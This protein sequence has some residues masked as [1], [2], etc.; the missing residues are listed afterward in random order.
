MK[1]KAST[2]GGLKALGFSDADLYAGDK[3]LGYLLYAASEN[4]ALA[5]NLMQAISF[6]QQETVMA[7]APRKVSAA[8]RTKKVKKD[9]SLSKKN[10][11]SLFIGELEDPESALA[12]FLGDHDVTEATV[13]AV[14]A[15]YTL[16]LLDGLSEAEK[17]LAKAAFADVLTELDA[18]KFMEAAAEIVKEEDEEDEDEESDFLEDEEE[19]DEPVS[20][21]AKVRANT[22][23]ALFD[24]L[25]S[26]LGSNGELTSFLKNQLAGPDIPDHLPEE[27]K[28][29]LRDMHEVTD[30]NVAEAVA[31]Y[32]VGFLSEEDTDVY[33]DFVSDAIKYFVQRFDLK[34]LADAAKNAVVSDVEDDMM[35]EELPL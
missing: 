16:S 24:A 18:G 34:A 29:A 14:L 13:P 17:G 7:T 4:P 11:T 20:A 23:E 10:L 27:N 12:A 31:E 30:E 28:R 2:V 15:D 35:D 5:S 33:Y 32:V 19:E 3:L 9:P 22:P 8:P 26:S 1:I 25:L 21:R 6:V